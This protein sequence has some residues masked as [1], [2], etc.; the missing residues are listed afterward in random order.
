[1]R[2]FVAVRLGRAF[3]SALMRIQNGMRT[4]GIRGNYSKPENLHI[5]LAFI[6]EYGDPQK[7][8]DAVKSVKFEP[9]DIKLSRLGS[10]PGIFWAGID[11]C[12]R[13]NKCADDVRAALSERGI[14]YD[15]KK[16][17]PH[18]TLIRQPDKAAYPKIA[19]PDTKMTV[20]RISLMR[21]DRGP[22]G[23][24]YTEIV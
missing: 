20:G 13:L 17:S 21:S 18:I 9:F 16:F 5:T 8:L 7:A 14:Q 24:V 15:R 19:V 2:L 1:M 3:E 10:F 22:N 11:G 6:G 12:D 23:M 4:A